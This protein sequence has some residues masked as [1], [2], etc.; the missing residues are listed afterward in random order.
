MNLVGD[1]ILTF[2]KAFNM[3]FILFIDKKSLLFEFFQ[4]VS[5]HFIFHIIEETDRIRNLLYFIGLY[6]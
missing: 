4:E 3:I 5:L 2:Y 1:P 6:D